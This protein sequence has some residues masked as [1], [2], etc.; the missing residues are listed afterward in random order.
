VPSEYEH[1][2]IWALEM[3]HKKQNGDFLEIGSIDFD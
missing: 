1:K 3:S 2:K